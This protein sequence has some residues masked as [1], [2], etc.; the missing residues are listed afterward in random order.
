MEIQNKLLPSE[1]N[2]SGSVLTKMAG[3]ESGV[4]VQVISESKGRGLVATREFVKGETLFREKPMVSCQF[5]WNVDYGYK[6][7]HNCMEPLE[8][9]QENVT[10][11][12]GNPNLILPYPDCCTTRYLVPS[13]PVVLTYL[14]YTIYL[15]A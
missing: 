3:I 13:P 10:R 2:F 8:T 6:A 15:K 4:V 7:C 5:S 1:N 12:S 9:A 14:A 11:L